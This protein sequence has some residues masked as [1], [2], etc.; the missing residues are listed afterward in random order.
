MIWFKR[1]LRLY[2]SRHRNSPFVSLI[3]DINE[4]TSLF[5][6]MSIIKILKG[7]KIQERYDLYSFKIRL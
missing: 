7:K 1:N 2:C 3:K 5:L 4:L 6:K